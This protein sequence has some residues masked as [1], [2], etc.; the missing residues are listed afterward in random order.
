MDKFSEYLRS[1]CQG[2]RVFGQGLVQPES[3]PL[4]AGHF[5]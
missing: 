5:T 2:L 4:V 3:G 1:Q